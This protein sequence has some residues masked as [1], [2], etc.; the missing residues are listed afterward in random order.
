MNELAEFAVKILKRYA[1]E[2]QVTPR[3]TSDLSK[4]E[5][6]LIAELHQNIKNLKIWK[7]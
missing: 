1:K 2:N 5:E 6:W 7:K 3:S 4:L